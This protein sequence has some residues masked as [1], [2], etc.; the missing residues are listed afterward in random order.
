MET[1]KLYETK[2]RA[3]EIL[4]ERKGFKKYV[5]EEMKKLEKASKYEEK[6]GNICV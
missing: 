6:R 3:L 4:S 5:K 1:N 2:K